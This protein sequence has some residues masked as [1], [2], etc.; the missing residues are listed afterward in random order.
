MMMMVLYSDRSLF[1]VHCTEHE[2]FPFQVQPRNSPL[3][4]EG[5]VPRPRTG[6]TRGDTWDVLFLHASQAATDCRAHLINT[7]MAFRSTIRVTL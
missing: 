5:L 1:Q 6:W 3:R 2:E 4:D 7:E